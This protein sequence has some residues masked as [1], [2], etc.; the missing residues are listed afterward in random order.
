MP[1]KPPSFTDQG[2]RLELLEGMQTL[3]AFA[4]LVQ[5]GSFEEKWLHDGLAQVLP[6]CSGRF[7]AARSVTKLHGSA[8]ANGRHELRRQSKAS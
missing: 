5:L 8:S 3:K 1:H 6:C 7:S 4:S 2:Y